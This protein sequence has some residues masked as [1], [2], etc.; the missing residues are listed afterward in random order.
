MIY[1]YRWPIRTVDQ[2]ALSWLHLQKKNRTLCL[3]TTLSQW[4][5]TD[6]LI[7]FQRLS[8]NFDEPRDCTLNVDQ[9][10]QNPI[11]DYADVTKIMYCMGFMQSVMSW[12]RPWLQCDDCVCGFDWQAGQRMS[13]SGE[14]WPRPKHWVMGLATAWMR[15]LVT[16]TSQFVFSIPFSA[17]LGSTVISC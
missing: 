3:L 16:R 9:F 2:M 1:G 5:V 14:L 10:Q 12:S 17:T 8:Y 11:K 4:W 13:G 7:Y 6:R 15:L